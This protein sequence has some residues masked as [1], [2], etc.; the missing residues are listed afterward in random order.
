MNNSLV[1][2][3][4]GEEIK[5]NI[6][7][8]LREEYC[9]GKGEFDTRLHLIHPFFEKVLGY[10]GL[11]DIRNEDRIDQN[12]NQRVDMIIG[13]GSP[14]MIV[15]CKKHGLTLKKEHFDQLDDY[16]QS[17][18]TTKIGILTNG[19][20]Y[21][22]YFRQNR[23]SRLDKNPFFIFDVSDNVKQ[24]RHTL[25]H[26]HKDISNFPEL[27][28]IAEAEHFLKKFKRSLVNVI[29]ER[30]DVLSKA[31]CQDMGIKRV[32]KEDLQ[33]VG[34]LMT[35]ESFSQAIHDIKT[36][37]D[38]NSN[39]PVLTKEELQ[40]YHVVRTLLADSR[41]VK[42]S[43]LYRISYQDYKGHFSIQVD[44]NQQRTIASFK[45]RAKDVEVTIDG[46]K[47]H[48]LNTKPEQL[49]KLKK[50]LVNSAKKQLD[51]RAKN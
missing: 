48:V 30:P 21:Q 5:R 33:R 23:R 43:E 29:L 7:K 51:K 14:K 47:F 3:Q 12:G 40:A 15:E 34:E 35:P 22:F 42:T 19:L 45:D 11:N 28:E 25:A 26:V 9:K 38:K 36:E 1:R 6:S 10:S 24:E 8:H 41:F 37:K 4:K 13:S 20:I 44:E 31:I 32:R 17:Y 50:E 49:T 46:E 16:A 18:P 2:Q 39:A 27:Y